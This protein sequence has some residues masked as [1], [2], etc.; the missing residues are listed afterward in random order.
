MSDRNCTNCKYYKQSEHR[1]MTFHSCSRW[2]CEYEPKEEE[3]E[4]TDADSD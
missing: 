4:K 3:K 1:G 2:N